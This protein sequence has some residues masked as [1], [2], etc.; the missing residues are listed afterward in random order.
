[1]KEIHMRYT[2][3]SHPDFPN[4]FLIWDNY[5]FMAVVIPGTGNPV[6]IDSLNEKDAKL[7]ASNYNRIYETWRHM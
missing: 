7:I 3:N 1:M 6:K 5:K 4:R 2:V